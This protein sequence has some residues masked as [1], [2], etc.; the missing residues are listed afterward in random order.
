MAFGEL[1]AWQLLMTVFGE[2]EFIADSPPS[3]ALWI[4]NPEAYGGGGAEVTGDGYA[5]VDTVVADWSVPIGPEATNITQL[6]F[7]EAEG[8]WG[9][10]THVALFSLAGGQYYF[11]GALITPKEIAEGSI[12][13]FDIGALTITFI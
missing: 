2:T 13:R 12:A 7:E 9:E 10:V 4:G 6:V 5:R 11:Y 8:Y 1:H 3:I